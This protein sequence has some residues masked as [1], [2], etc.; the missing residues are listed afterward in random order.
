MSTPPPL[1]HRTRTLSRSDEVRRRFL[2]TVMAASI[3]WSGAIAVATRLHWVPLGPIQGANTVA[4]FLCSCILL[5]ALWRRPDLFVGIARTY[6]TLAF[7]YVC[8]AQFLV[9][10]DQLRTLLFFPAI[11][12][13][14]LILGGLAAWIFIVLAIATVLIAT[15]G[16]QMAISPLAAS[17]FVITLCLT[18]LF[19]HGFR[20]QAITALNIVSEQNA[21]LDAAARQDHLTHLLNLRA[22]REAMQMHADQAAEAAFC[23]AFLD[24]DHFKSI[25]DRYG[26][27]SGDAVLVAVA[28]ALRSAARKQ[29]VVARVGGEEFAVLLPGCDLAGA[30][31]AAERLR[32]AVQ[33]LA[34]PV[35]DTELAV[36]ISVGVAA[37]VPF[38][39]VDALLGAADAAMYLAK[40]QGRNRVAT[41]PVAPPA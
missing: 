36:T 25:N 26:H 18:G 2:M 37:A 12:A 23:V 34:V 17:T 24:V 4:F 32:A 8:A 7:A 39:S 19:F 38:V 10:D 1:S 41:L 16:G 21:A 6:V 33:A 14:F 31:L 28:G 35:R 3:V 15:L 22:F 29:D 9:L 13:T 5:P 30:I 11:G 20:A 27:A 40:A